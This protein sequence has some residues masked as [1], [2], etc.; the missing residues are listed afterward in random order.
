MENGSVLPELDGIMRRSP[1]GVTMGA[2]AAGGGGGLYVASTC[3][4][5]MPS[6]TS[7]VTVFAPAAIVMVKS[8]DWKSEQPC[9]NPGCV[10]PMVVP[11]RLTMPQE[12][13]KLDTLQN[14]MCTRTWV[15]ISYV[16]PLGLIVP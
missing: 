2:I 11:F 4:G 10:E 8:P 6:T 14:S 5:A 12:S 3:A 15:P 1:S 9:A 16:P 13:K 7:P